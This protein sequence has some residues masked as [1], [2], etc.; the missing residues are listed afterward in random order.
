[1][2]SGSSFAAR[3][4]MSSAVPTGS[5]ARTTYASIR[6]PAASRNA[7]PDTVTAAAVTDG[8]ASST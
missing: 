7:S 6:T 2:C 1:M 3:R 5:A 8:S 4:R